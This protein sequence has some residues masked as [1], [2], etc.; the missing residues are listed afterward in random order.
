MRLTTYILY[1]YVC[2][3]NTMCIDPNQSRCN[4]V[5][6]ISIPYTCISTS[7]YRKHSTALLHFSF[8]TQLVIA[9]YLDRSGHHCVN[10]QCPSKPKV[11]EFHPSSFANQDVLRLHIPMQDAVGVKVEQCGHQLTGNL[12]DLHN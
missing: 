6:N 1:T 5:Y 10:T 8:H 3:Y 12:L 7:K 2:E 4:V 9:Q 11:T